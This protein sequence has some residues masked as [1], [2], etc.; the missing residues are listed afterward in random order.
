VAKQLIKENT[1]SPETREEVWG[2]PL[3]GFWNRGCRCFL[4][5]DCQCFLPRRER[6][7]QTEEEEKEKEGEGKKPNSLRKKPQSSAKPASNGKPNGRKKRAGIG[8]RAKR[9]VKS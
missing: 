1:A 9:R 3:L 2:G 6:Q 5:G 7:K 4:E 8:E